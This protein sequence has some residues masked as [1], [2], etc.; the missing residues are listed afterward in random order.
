M[1]NKVKDPFY[2]TELPNG[3]QVGRFA[4]LD[5][6][7]VTHAVTTRNGFDVAAAGKN[8]KGAAIAV[9]QAMNLSAVAY[10][11]QVH[12][13]RIVVPHRGGLA[14]PAD[15]MVTAD[16]AMGLMGLAADCPLILAADPVSG[17]VGLAHASWR[18]TVMRITA[19]LVSQ[20]VSQF[21]ADPADLVACI[22]P[23]AG[24]CCYEIGPDV[25]QLASAGLGLRAQQFIEKRQA[26]IYLDLWAANIDELVQAG[27]ERQNV[28]TAGLCTVCRNDLFPSH[29]AEG[30]QAGRFVAVIAQD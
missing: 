8:P 16:S 3:W 26:K 24:P 10:C 20:F 14:G 22:C 18:G 23:S 28:H 6:L 25:L 11:R 30:E 21:R 5:E 27:L 1:S 7:G 12:G 29:R 4:A 19:E 15:G 17:A 13:R 2:F 9:Q